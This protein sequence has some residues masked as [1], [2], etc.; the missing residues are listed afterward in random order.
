MME[1]T[2][3]RSIFCNLFH[4]LASKACDC[5]ENGTVTV[6]NIFALL[7]QAMER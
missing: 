3:I 4:T 1:R 2:K 7:W 5:S 6:E